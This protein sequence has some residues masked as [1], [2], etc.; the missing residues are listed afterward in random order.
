MTKT[1]GKYVLYI[2]KTSSLKKFLNVIFSNILK[3]NFSILRVTIKQKK[4]PQRMYVVLCMWI[5]CYFTTK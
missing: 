1:L 3:D 4:N 5:S 2:L